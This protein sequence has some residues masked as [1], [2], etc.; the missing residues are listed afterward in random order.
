MRRTTLRGLPRTLRPVSAI[1]LPPK[2]P[3]HL[4][5]THILGVALLQSTSM[6]VWFVFPILA[7][8]RFEAND[9]QTL[10]ITAS[11][12]VLFALSIFWNDLFSRRSFAKYLLTWWAVT[13]LPLAACAF[14]WDYWS[15][16][17]P[18]FISCLGVAGATPALGDLL[19]SLYPDATRGRA[20]SLM[21]G[22]SMVFGALFGLG[23]GRWLKHDENAFRYYLPLAAALQLAGAGVCI[24]LAEAAGHNAKRELVADRGQSLWSR[25]VEPVTHAKEVLK[26]DPIFARYEAAYMT[27][28]IGWMIA[29]ALLPMLITDKLHLDYDA[30]TASTQTSYLLALVVFLLPAGWLMDRLG[31]VRSTGISFAMLSVYP[32]L[33]LWASDSGEL[34]IASLVYG[35]AHAGASVGWMLG[36]VALA[37]T[38][39]KVPQYV[40]IHATLVGVRGKLF[41]GLGVGLYMLLKGTGVPEIIRGFPIPL[42]IA[43]AAYV[44]SAVQMFQLHARMERTRRGDAIV[45]ER[46]V[47]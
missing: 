1:A 14:A 16:L 38:P 19:K 29:F 26:A 22:V 39:G 21:W 33:Y 30:A 5:L 28:G 35:V 4:L 42:I 37:P 11:S 46:A 12:S 24:W 8:K 13:C 31:A 2:L 3:L 7:R 17:I 10:I 9:W 45:V 44:W 40:A 32:L 15:L 47:K 25:V 36:P 27:Y 18:Y 34:A 41:Q 6:A 43:S 20:Y 23:V